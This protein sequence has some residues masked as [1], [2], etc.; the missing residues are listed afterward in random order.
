MKKIKLVLYLLA[1]TTISVACGSGD[2]KTSETTAALETEISTTAA[3]TTEEVTTEETTEEETTEPDTEAP[4][5]TIPIGQAA[6]LNDWNITVDEMQIMPSVPDNYG[7]FD[8][9][10]GNQY[11]L[12]SISVSNEGKEAGTFLKSFG[13]SD[14]VST[15]VIYGD[16][17]EFSPTMLL[18]YSKSMVD[19]S[20][21]P[22]SS[23]SGDIAFEIPDSVADSTDELILQFTAGNSALHF[24]I[25]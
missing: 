10:E 24:K 15:L 7:K 3:E 9:D 18:G 20:I 17:Y 16:G 4:L 13:L 1:V 25:R 19:S 11:L 5:E 14:D 2:P 8:A 6:T 12:V 21:N 23:K 22:L